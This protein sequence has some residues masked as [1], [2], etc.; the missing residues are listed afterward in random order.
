MPK[1]R[2]RPDAAA[3]HRPNLNIPESQQ[4]AIERRH[5]LDD[6][7]R[8]IRDQQPTGIPGARNAGHGRRPP[9]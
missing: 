3:Q 2:N 9:S 4:Q 7:Q 8:S 5:H 6:Q 1:A